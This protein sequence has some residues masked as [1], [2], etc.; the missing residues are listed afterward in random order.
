MIP[1][2]KQLFFF[3]FICLAPFVKAQ[4][5]ANLETGFLFTG[6]NDIRDGKNGTTFFYN[7]D[8][9]AQSAP[10][11]RLRAGR[12]FDKHH[13]SLLFTPL[14]L[15]AKA[16]FNY[17]LVFG[18]EL[19]KENTP[20][21][22]QYTFSSYRLTYTYKVIDG[23]KLNLSLGGSAKIRQAGIILKNNTLCKRSLSFGFVPLINL[24]GNYKFN[25][26]WALH[27]FADA[28]V[29]EQGRAEDV[30]LA[31][32]YRLKENVSIQGG[33]R[34]FEG[35]SDG[36]SNYNFILLHIASIGINWEL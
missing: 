27:L 29:A 26:K 31:L 33:Y 30:L 15:K 23:S 32:K 17:P 5:Y 18:G 11:F 19:F 3:C 12:N 20:I 4:F 28:L 22:A 6:Y 2:L 13:L 10:F 14:T 1:Q 25:D 36:F 16:T 9:G 8:F 21:H 7:N 35:G 34:I 24:Q